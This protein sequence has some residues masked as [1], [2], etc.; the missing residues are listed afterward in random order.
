MSNE[1]KSPPL[2]IYLDQ[3]KWI[4]LARIVYGKDAKPGSK[5]V[6]ERIRAAIS[7]GR[8]VL[9]LSAVHYMEL[10][11]I[12]NR[13]RR[14][15]LGAVMHEFS[16]GVTMAPVREII[17]HEIEIALISRW[18]VLAITPFSLLG[19]GVD[20]AFGVDIQVS[21]GRVFRERFERSVLAGDALLDLDSPVQRDSEH[22]ERFQRHL[23][24]L[25][26]IRDRLAPA[27]WE[28]ALNAITMIDII[29]P[30]NCVFSRHGLDKA[31]LF[32]QGKAEL[33]GWLQSLP[34][35]QV[36]LH[37]HRQ[38]LKDLD[39]RSK[40][41]DLEDWAGLIIASVYCDVLV[42]EKHM[43]AML[44][45]D[46]FQSSARIERRLADAVHAADSITG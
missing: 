38:V 41:T 35:R 25:K 14:H 10:A 3:N 13:E 15:R 36:D 40:L 8:W 28:D 17:K 37:L 11:R 31:M 23:Q 30:L 22:R 21:G 20:H 5:V 42:C 45:R 32:S 6:L 4:E 29:D 9:P 34:S 2:L 16:G 33:T 7:S 18:P 39:Y 26:E 1:G 27:S 24:G 12:S 43:A 19:R 46:G 44:R